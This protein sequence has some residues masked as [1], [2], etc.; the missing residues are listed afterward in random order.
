MFNS[1]AD[2]SF[3]QF[4]IVLD[5]QIRLHQLT[6]KNIAVYV[7][8]LFYRVSQG[9]LSINRLR[10]ALG[11]IARE[12]SILRTA[13]RLDSVS[14]NLTQYIQ[15]DNDREWFAFC[16]SSVNKEEDKNFLQTILFEETT[17]RMHFDLT[18]G[19]VC[20]CHIVRHRSLVNSDDDDILSIGDWIIFNF[21]HVAVDGE[22]ERIFL[23]ELQK[24]YSHE[25]SLEAN[26]EQTTLKYIDCKL[27]CYCVLPI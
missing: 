15:P 3:A 22:S 14:G 6:D 19:Q 26:G 10:R 11:Q 21:H 24:F 17:N 2:A 23:D 16:T 20:R 1:L 18:Q 5:E 12:H 25:Q 9:S 13:L 8:P 7:I 4:R 27:H